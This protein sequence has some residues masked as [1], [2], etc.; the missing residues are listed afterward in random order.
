MFELVVGEVGAIL[1]GLEEER[2][3][4]DLVLEAWLQA[5][6]DG[7]LEAFE[8]LGRRLDDARQRHDDA[9]AL[10]DRLFGDDFE[11]A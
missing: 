4:P 2:E 9:K 3:F 8:A 11:A 6:E 5:T 1:G 7:R 10:D